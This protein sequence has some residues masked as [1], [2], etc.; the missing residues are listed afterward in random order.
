M[1]E[2]GPRTVGRGC[3]DVAN[4]QEMLGGVTVCIAWLR[5]VSSVS[6]SEEAL[7]SDT[8]RSIRGR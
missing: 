7:G 1:W 3:N 6:W 8:T 2:Q 4:M 5:A